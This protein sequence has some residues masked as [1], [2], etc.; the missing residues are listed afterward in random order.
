MIFLGRNLSSGP[1]LCVAEISGNHL[2]SLERA[3]RLIELAKEAG[4]DAVKFQCYDA[5]SM[6]I[7]FDG[8]EF[9]VQ[10]PLWKD[11]TLYDLYRQA[12]TPLE[13]M[14]ELFAHARKHRIPAFASVFCERGLAVL[15][16]VGCPV[17]KIAS[18]EITDIP[19]I[20]KVAATGKPI[21]LSTGMA[22]LE[23]I[24]AAIKAARMSPHDLAI[25]HCVSSYPCPPED[26]NLD[27]LKYFLE[28]SPLTIGLS[29]HTHGIDIPIAAAA[30]GARII[31]KHF[32]DSRQ[33][34]GSDA[35]FSLEPDEFR[36]MV[37]AMRDKTVR[38]MACAILPGDQDKNIAHSED[39]SRQLRRS[40]YAV[41]DISAGEEFTSSN[42]RSIRPS[43][44]LPPAMLPEI[45]GK[46]AK[47]D[48]V[49]GAAL[50]R[51]MIQ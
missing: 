24:N 30:L 34:G 9:Q 11:Q 3:L 18:F 46:Q 32:T 14:P 43:Y 23:E 19:L 2:G 33:A 1:P 25:L 4:A 44:G 42:V 12:C 10:N 5:D 21:I 39:S 17:Y 47:V 6:T 48:I 38:D 35:A 31:E 20:E 7:K 49:R 45:L 37:K 15:E 13:W 40:L 16:E 51:E 22:T 50:K 29:D 36:A 8:P 41:Q 27:R 28:I 26:A